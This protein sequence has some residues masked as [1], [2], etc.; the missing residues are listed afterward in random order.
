MTK[1]KSTKR[2]LL[3]SALALIMCFSMLIG[4]TYAWFSDTAST[5]VNTIQAGTLDIVLEYKDA[6]GNWQNAEGTSL[7]FKDLDSNTYWEPGCTYE[8]PAVRVRN[9]GNLALKYQIVI[10][11]VT[12]NAK[13]LEAIE[14]TANDGAISTFMGHLDTKGAFSEEIVIKGHMKEEAGNE[15]QGLTLEGIGITVYATQYTYEKDSYNDKY[16][17]IGEDI[18][19]NGT[20]RYNCINSGRIMGNSSRY[21]IAADITDVSGVKTLAVNVLDQNGKLMTTI[22]PE[23]YQIPADGKI[24]S[25]TVS[26]VVIGDSSSWENT[27]FVP[28]MSSI[29]TTMEL[30]V[31]GAVIGVT[32]VKPMAN[33]SPVTWAEIVTAYAKQTDVYTNKIASG[34]L[35]MY[36]DKSRA[37]ISADLQNVTGVET[38]AANVYDQN[39]KLITTITPEGFTIPATGTITT[40]T[41]S[42]VVIGN[43][44]SWQNTAFKP[45]D[46]AV[47]T[48]IELVVNGEVVAIDD[49]NQSSTHPNAT[50]WDAIVE[51]YN[52]AN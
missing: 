25:A 34:R 19:P 23:G 45:S 21:Q 3:M 17:L 16:D 36:A 42:A 32:D 47:P 13:L 5:G 49:I 26:A 14:F 35:D 4:S 10:N 31:N 41:I 27:A 11:G 43:S 46:N 44:S 30:V 33:A 48:V 39:G 1:Q 40:A 6:D 24:S 37:Q 18:Y 8:L 38:L 51:A 9:N 2:A 29:P 28:S 22:T 12:G 7:A 20:F 52:A 50:T 15:Y